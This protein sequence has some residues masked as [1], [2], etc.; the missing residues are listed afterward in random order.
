MAT[1]SIY[2]LDKLNKEESAQFGKALE[3][4]YSL[5]LKN[6]YKPEPGKYKTLS[7]EEIL[8]RIAARKKDE[9]ALH[10]TCK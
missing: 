8:Q 4:A 6:P 7:K 5:Y 1:E 10:K 2:R 9:R 3:E